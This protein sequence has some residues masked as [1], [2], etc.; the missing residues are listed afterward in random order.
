MK[1]QK[2]I[3]APRRPIHCLIDPGTLELAFS[4][5]TCSPER[6]SSARSFCCCVGRRQRARTARGTAELP[7]AAQSTATRCAGHT[8]SRSAPTGHRGLGHPRTRDGSS[9]VSDGS[10]A[11]LVG[12]ALS[13]F[14]S[15]SATGIPNYYQHEATLTGLD[16]NTNVC[17]ISAT[18]T[19]TP[20]R[21]RRSVPTAPPSRER[22]PSVSSRSATV[23]AGRAA[24]VAWRRPL[25]T[26]PSTSHSQR[27]R[28]VRRGTYA[29]FEARFFPYY[30]NW[31]RRKGIFPAIGNHDDMTARPRL[32][33][34]CSCCRAMVRRPPIRTT[35]SDSTASTTVRRTSS[36]STRRRRFCRRRG[37]RSS[38][39]GSQPTFRQ[40][41]IGPGASPSSTVLPTSGAEHGSDLAIRQAFGPLFEQAQRPDCPD[42]ARAQLRTHGP[43]ARKQQ[44]QPAGRDVRH[45]GGA[46]A[47][48]Y[49]VG[50]SAFTAFSRSVDHYVRM[51]LS[52][53][54]ATLEAVGTT[55][56]YSTASRSTWRSSRMPPRRKC[57]LSPECGHGLERHRDDSGDGG[58]R[59]EGGKSG[60]VDRW[61]ATGHRPHRART[62][63]R[64]IRRHYPTA[65]ALEARAY[66][67]DG[68]RTT[69]SRTVTVSNGAPGS[70]VVLYRVRSAGPGRKLARGHRHQRRGRAPP[71]TPAGRRGHDRSPAREP[72]GLRRALGERHAR[73]EL[74]PLAAAQ[75]RGQL[76][77][78]RL[79]V[80]P[81]IRH[82]R[83]GRL[84]GLSDRHGVGD[85]GQPAG[86]RRLHDQ[87]L[88]MAGQRLRHGR[89][90]TGAEVCDR[91]RADDQDPGREDGVSID[92]VVLSP[93]SYLTR[94]PGALKNDT[95]ILAK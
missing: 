93:A 15:S 95:T 22:A 43:V 25:G 90:R 26:T 33:G 5:G 36:R 69:V 39:P 48:L 7:A 35:P 84:S 45:L 72:G 52:P 16:A 42:R 54:D 50:R 8:S 76:R 34:R 60:F 1:L 67:L 86:L 10:G 68:R 81:D 21:R 17:L 92:Q 82:R 29:E 94:A 55:A 11:L 74:S 83:C 85:A 61:R 20:P 3:L 13:T 59:R 64:S 51:A 12:T 75:G 49:P 71:R 2:G 4:D 28:G 19:S 18:R 46:G 53:T 77:L 6:R 91:R 47:A 63:L 30:R 24:R 31:L 40:R 56:R 78:Q 57:R 14:R 79:G 73:H 9:R 87:W 32:T 66:D 88:G 65:H 80:G 23:A 62:R 38:S 27:R 41:R 70:D 89:P 58:R 37:G 44:R